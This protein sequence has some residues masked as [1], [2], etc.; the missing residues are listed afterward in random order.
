[1]SAP[2]RV[3]GWLLVLAWVHR[4]TPHTLL[5]TVPD[6]PGDASVVT[7]PMRALLHALWAHPSRP[8][9]GNAFFPHDSTLLFSDLLAG[10]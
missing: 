10:L 4:P 8:F 9:D 3:I 1:M 5:H 6:N 2:K 7:W